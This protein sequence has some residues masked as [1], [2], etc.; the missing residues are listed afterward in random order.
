MRSL[1]RNSDNISAEFSS[2]NEEKQRAL[3]MEILFY[4]S[5]FSRVLLP[6]KHINGV[7]IPT[8]IFKQRPLIF[9]CN[10]F[11]DYRR[12]L[13]VS[14]GRMKT[15]LL[16]YLSSE[17]KRRLVHTGS[18][19]LRTPLYIKLLGSALL[20]SALCGSTTV[21]QLRSGWF[22]IAFTHGVLRKFPGQKRRLVHIGSSKLR[23]P[24]HIK[25]LGSALLCSLWINNCDST[26]IWVLMDMSWSFFS[27]EILAT[28]QPHPQEMTE[29]GEV[30]GNQAGNNM[31][32]IGINHQDVLLGNSSSVS[33]KRRKKQSKVWEEMTKFT[34]EDG[35]DRA[36]CNHCQK[37]FDG[38]SKK[39]TTHL[40]NHL[41]RCPR[42]RN[43]GA[44]DDNADKRMDQTANLTSPVVIEE[45]CVIDLIKSCF[46]E[47]GELTEN[48]DPFVLNSRKVEILQVYEEKKELRRFYSRLSCRLSIG[49]GFSRV[50][51]YFVLS[52]HYIDDSWEP[53]MELISFCAVN[54]DEKLHL[55]YRNLVKVLKESC[56]DFKIDGDICSIIYCDYNDYDGDGFPFFEGDHEDVIGEINSW[57]NQRGNSLP[58]GGLLFSYD[59]LACIYAE[60]DCSLGGCLWKKFGEIRECFDYVKTPSNGQNFRIAKD[61]V[62]K[63]F[64]NF[65]FSV[66][67][68]SISDFGKVVGYKEAFLELERMDSDF[69]S[70]SINLT[71]EQWD[72]A[73][74][75]QQH[76]KEFLDSFDSLAKRKYTTL[77]QYFPNFCD[78]YMKLVPVRQITPTVMKKL[79]SELEKYN[80]VLVIAVILDPR[81]K[82][83]I[84]QLWY[85]KIY[86]RDSDR[87]L[88]KIIHDFTDVYN[89]YYAKASESE[90]TTSSSSS[91]LDAMGRPCKFSPKSSSELERYLNESKVPS[92]QKF[93]IL[94][95]WRAYAPIFPTLS[96]MARDFL[97]IPLN[98][99]YPPDC[100]YIF[101]CKD[102]DEDIKPALSC[103]TQWLN[104][105]E[106]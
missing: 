2:S 101:E 62:G 68:P 82:M 86:G 66:D 83:D 94:A 26:E 95:W 87:Y 38:S 105:H 10:L 3:V 20:C 21:I 49:I 58:F 100:Y 71:E 85:N 84:V 74:A 4:S 48:W 78:V 80:L 46:D 41:Q 93:D 54:E 89:K 1:F 97:A 17:Q 92:V 29:E 77:N 36:R 40:N 88:E 7:P 50:F 39:G 22:Q 64:E 81:F 23:T 67:K 103:L 52:V 72:E 15:D 5:I 47:D 57:F 9:C 11:F 44:G 65:R 31:E 19:K 59:T 53:K 104:S 51:R 55:D 45:K 35:R 24:L 76:C 6:R 37:E 16:R 8:S 63:K 70:R 79:S 99:T 43:N 106:K 98:G 75:M 27:N 34:G 14:C 28:H 18:S 96:R 13:N 90:D 69:K 91:Y 102:L 30:N 60:I 56:L 25:L 73:T 42:K 33:N 32:L 12:Y 61:N